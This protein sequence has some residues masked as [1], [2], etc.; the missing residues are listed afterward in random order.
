[1][2]LNVVFCAVLAWACW[3]GMVRG[4]D[5]AFT[6]EPSVR[7]AQSAEEKLFRDRDAI[8]RLMMWSM[9]YLEKR[10]PLLDRMPMEGVHRAFLESYIAVP[11]RL[12]EECPPDYRKVFWLVDAMSKAFLQRMEKEKLAGKELIRWRMW[13]AV[14][15]LRK[16]K[17]L[18]LRRKSVGRRRNKDG[19]YPR[20][21]LLSTN[22]QA[23]FSRRLGGLL[24]GN[25]AGAGCGVTL[26]AE[27]GQVPADA[28]ICPGTCRR[29]Q[30]HV[31][32]D[33]VRADCHPGI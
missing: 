6:Q 33:L 2:M 1:M 8:I 28:G 12:V 23:D 16:K 15:L 29:C 17:G 20:Q 5:V 11:V 19:L 14:F 4:Q 24:P 7:E 22:D 25:G 13:N 30:V 21:M 10:A 26:H 27:C 32:L 9:L 3:L 18:S 31:F